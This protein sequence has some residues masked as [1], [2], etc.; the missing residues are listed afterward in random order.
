MPNN[1]AD[2]KC[3]AAALLLLLL[4]AAFLISGFR[5]LTAADPWSRSASEHGPR[6]TVHVSVP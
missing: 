5:K 3:S 6:G 4:L 1:L 2:A